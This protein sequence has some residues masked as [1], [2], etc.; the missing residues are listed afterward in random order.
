M[1]YL[2]WASEKFTIKPYIFYHNDSK[3]THLYYDPRGIEWQMEQAGQYRDEAGT[4]KKIRES[5]ERIKKPLK[6]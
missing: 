5:L 6:L 3:G 4:I 1:E 2:P